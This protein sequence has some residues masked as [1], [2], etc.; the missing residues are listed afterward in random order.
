MNTP[1]TTFDVYLAGN[2]PPG[3]PDAQGLS[4]YLEDRWVRGNAG[5]R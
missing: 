3:T 2:L 1:N 4:G 5:C